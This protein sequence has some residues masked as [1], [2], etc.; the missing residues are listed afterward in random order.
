MEIIQRYL[1]AI[2]FWLPK[3]QK[4]D[5]IAEISEDLHSQME[6][7]QGQLSRPLNDAEVDALLKQRGNPLLVANRY[8]P[9]QSLIGPAF[10]PLY[11]FVL[12]VWAICWSL[13]AFLICIIVQRTQHPDLTWW[14]ALGA[15]G[16]WVWGAA[17][18]AVSMIT[19]A[20][21]LLERIDSK[22]HF[23]ENWNPRKLPPARDPNN[24]SRF[25][26][27]IEL[28]ANSAWLVAFICYGSS[29][30]IVNG[31]ALRLTLA[32]VW[33]YFFWGFLAFGL[34]ASALSAVNLM[35][36][37]WTG[38]RATF[39]LVTDAIGG[40]LWCWLMKA[41]IVHELWIANAH[42][43]AGVDLSHIINTWTQWS[44]PC[45]VIVIMVVLAVDLYRILRVNRKNTRGLKPQVAAA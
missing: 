38:A 9:Q 30:N 1:H 20:F 36:P 16:D 35:Q 28:V 23:L 11:V 3:A 19:L 26:A 39:R 31:P 22:T 41:N 43:P 7:R 44:F 40:A 14:H 32:P 25:S 24:V 18:W 17:F 45:T 8:L 34:L 15:A 2:E 37:H 33:M 12:K 27:A 21:V 29:L 5:I 42:D 13:P 6:E 10:F 4:A